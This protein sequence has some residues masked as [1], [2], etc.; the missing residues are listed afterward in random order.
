MSMP[1]TAVYENGYAVFRKYN[2]RLAWQVSH[3]ETETETCGM[4]CAPDKDLGLGIR[5]FD[6][7][8][9]AAS[10]SLV[11]YISQRL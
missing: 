5:A 6:C 1:K 2:V 7:R 3:V 8:H 4:K 10:G 11:D 9:H